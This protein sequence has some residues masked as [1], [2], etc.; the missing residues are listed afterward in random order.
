MQAA[1][2]IRTG[3]LAV[4]GTAA[5]V[6]G[7]ATWMIKADPEQGAVVGAIA[8]LV[9]AAA[10]MIIDLLGALR[11]EQPVAGPEDHAN[12]LAAEVERQWLREAAAR[13]LRDG[14]V[15][16]LAWRHHG[17]ALP[18]GD[19]FP[20]HSAPGRIVRLKAEGRANGDFET[21]A[22]TLAAYFEKTPGGRLVLVGEPGAGKT[23]LGLLLTVG[24]VRQ[25]AAGERVP[26][27]L[28]I[29][30]WD[31][32]AE[33]LED[34]LIRTMADSYYN[35]RQDV[36]RELVRSRLI[37]PIL[38]GLDEIPES[39]RRNAIAEINRSVREEHPVVITCRSNE[40]RDLVVGGS[41]TL[42]RAPVVEVVPV[43]LDDIVDYFSAVRWPT[44]TDWSPVFQRMREEPG[45]SLATAFSTPL[46]VSS[47]RL[48]MGGGAERPERLLGDKELES[49]HAIENWLT[50]Q[51]V[52]AAY[53]AED[54]GEH[55]HRRTARAERYLAYLAHHM[56]GQRERELTWWL[57]SERLLPAWFPPVLGLGAGVTAMVCIVAAYALI[58][59]DS[60]AGSN[61]PVVAASAGLAFAVLVTTVWSSAGTRPPRQLSLRR[62]GF[63]RRCG[64]GFV[65]G[66]GLAL[67]PAGAVVVTFIL[68]ISIGEVWSLE[69]LANLTRLCLGVT[70]VA[71]VTG[72]AT[73]ILRWLDAPHDKA[74][75]ADPVGL[76]RHD[77]R[78]S[79]VGASI[80]GL[81]FGGLLALGL[82][83]GIWLAE[84]ATGLLTSWPGWPG[85]PDL[86]DAWAVSVHLVT[87]RQFES[88]AMTM[89]G[90]GLLPGVGFAVLVLLTRAWPRYVI[91][92]VTLAAR[93]RLPLRL[94]SFLADAH[95]RGILRRSGALYQFRHGR[96]QEQ[97]A[98]RGA[99]HHGG[100]STPP[101]GSRGT[102]GERRRT[103]RP[104]IACT[105]VIVVC[106]AAAATG[107]PRANSRLA[108]N[109]ALAKGPYVL[110]FSPDGAL[111]AL[112]SS[113]DT[114]VHIFT[115]KDGKA[116]GSLPSELGKA[117]SGDVLF[118]PDGNWVAIKDR[119]GT[120]DRR[121]SVWNL[122][123]RT[124]EISL[125][126]RDDEYP[127]E[128]SV[129]FGAQSRTIAV[130]GP[131]TGPR[132]APVM[133]LWDL[134]AHRRAL[135][136]PYET[137][138]SPVFSPDS[139]TF[140]SL[141]RKN[142]ILRR[143]VDGRRVA[144]LGP[145][146]DQAGL[147][148]VVSYSP[149]G[150]YLLT[151]TEGTG[152]ALREAASGS[153][154]YQGEHDGSSGAVVEDY[155]AFSGDSRRA[156]IFDG[157]GVRMVDT[158]SGQATPRI[159]ASSGNMSVATN[160][161]GSVSMSLDWKGT[162]TAWDRS[163]RVQPYEGLS[164][165]DQDRTAALAADGRYLIVDEDGNSADDSPSPIAIFDT[166]NG[167]LIARPED[168][169][170]RNLPPAGWNRAPPV[171]IPDTSSQTIGFATSR[172]TIEFYRLADGR[173]TFEI[174]DPDRADGDAYDLFDEDPQ[175]WFLADRLV[176]REAADGP[177]H[178]LT[179]HDTHS[180]RTV[181]TVDDAVGE[182]LVTSRFLA[183]AASD[184][185]VR[186]WK[187]STGE[188]EASFRGHTGTVDRLALSPDGKQIATSSLDGT[189]RLWQIPGV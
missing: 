159:T 89:T 40:Y 168:A 146:F 70:A 98:L 179:V 144:T 64:G 105:L 73:A 189:V 4:A 148:G 90:L 51:T 52:R 22:G 25:R 42:S 187:L 182:P 53:S 178:R 129:R 37:V 94:S 61:V 165:P 109:G 1:K 176:V 108:L 142:V 36:A 177:G 62:A 7:A 9:L 10:S 139:T 116:V 114:M 97:L 2:R 186:L 87:A 135:R 60:S 58:E 118:S 15:L 93:G 38:D 140:V 81:V 115:T 85:D 80:G 54:T 162:L 125:P 84:M 44:G 59:G 13:G 83:A 181:V 164:E 134:N 158:G 67:L 41:P 141:E 185:V 56:H 133:T 166:R 30:S 12:D 78:S 35:G 136:L 32:I 49:R 128:Q 127:G 65:S 17:D 143:M 120:I 77:R 18:A 55:H 76:L 88:V 48:V 106:L 27:F 16:P 57:L 47:A 110:T 138:D 130:P 103:V 123:S 154:L 180:A 34:W 71:G 3:R 121:L 75:S 69:N 107:L 82:M 163:G 119:P 28:S 8:G 26:I 99:D 6:T 170:L 111:M 172:R 132:T 23:V 5:T 29:S 152:I 175:C 24:M 167:S 14:D 126:L 19:L 131:R 113:R 150:R 160:S 86:S 20:G 101:A 174:A 153:V 63:A 183:T 173:R 91:T 102:A 66:F 147:F 155:A 79:V 169:A 157:N 149:D 96:L 122:G 104:M 46:I 11:S 156:V 151:S 68:F 137:N 74:V 100:G 21:V 39:S 184:H 31:P 112:R 171:V 95:T 117:V 33:P 145:S 92:C 45:G 72:C 161:D 43:G 188:L 124:L 50:A